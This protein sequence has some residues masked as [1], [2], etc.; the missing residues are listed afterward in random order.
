MRLVIGRDR[1]YSIGTYQEYRLATVKL[2][3][4]HTADVHLDTAFVG[5]GLPPEYG[6]RRRQALRDVL[7]T[8]LRRAQEWP[9]DAVFIAGDLFEAERLTRDTLLFLQTQFS[10]LH[11]IPIFI[12]PGNHDP[13]T[14]QSVYNTTTWP[15]NVI[16]FR[17]P[18]WE[19]VTLPNVPLTVH[20]FGFDGPDISQN[21]FG[22]LTVPSDG[23]IHVA[24]AHGAEMASLPP[25]K[26]AY[27]PF[28][29]KQLDLPELRYVALG[30]YHTF[31]EIHTPNGTRLCYPGAPEG[32]GFNEVGERYFLEVE[33]SADTT[34]IR[35]VPSARTMYSIHRIDCSTFVTAQQLVEAIRGCSLNT[36]LQ[37]IARIELTG[38]CPDS[39]RDQLPAVRDAVAQHFEY[40]ELVEQLE[41]QEDYEAIARENTSLGTFVKQI[42][43]RIRLVNDDHLREVLLRAREVGV[44]A[45][46]GANLPLRGTDRG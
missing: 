12:T 41:P 16:I 38:T 21:P 15:S 33:I 26:G 13:C 29:A 10:A 9:A 5:S 43:E 40:L 37:H 7:Q 34:E 3:I 23:C 46:R 2:K 45:Y 4:I 44:A 35:K 39:L 1:Y 18:R 8:I 36:S 42:N 31:K 6:N 24:I 20:G 14:V 17:E 22:E 25:E 30:H 19:A 27:A 28:Q 11:P 32:L